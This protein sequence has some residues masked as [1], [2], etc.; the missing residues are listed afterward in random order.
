[1]ANRCG[2][3]LQIA[4]VHSFR[5]P[6]DGT[7]A[8]YIDDQLVTRFSSLPISAVFPVLPYGKH[9]IAAS[10]QDLE[11]E[12]VVEC[13]VEIFVNVSEGHSSIPIPPLWDFEG[14]FPHTVTREAAR[15]PVI[16]SESKVS[17]G[18]PDESLT[19]IWTCPDWEQDWVAELLAEGGIL[20]QTVV[21]A[22]DL[23]PQ[24][25]LA[26]NSLVVVSQNDER[27]RPPYSL[28]SY[29]LSFRARGFRVGNYVCYTDGWEAAE[30]THELACHIPSVL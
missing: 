4:N 6:T 20:H 25:P 28:A 1:M 23:G 12:V 2:I 29:L 9:T 3:G 24:A 26:R 13:E 16:R 14:G 27:N 11:N 17:D 7:I 5:V 22:A 10:A 8:I 18:D 21:A 30:S 15:R 19:V